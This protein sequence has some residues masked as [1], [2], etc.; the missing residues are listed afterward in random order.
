MSSL[1]VVSSAVK[2]AS[3]GQYI[4]ALAMTRGKLMDARAF[5]EAKGPAWARAAE[6]VKAA[7]TAIGT[8]D[9]AAALLSPVSYDFSELL[10]PLSVIGRLT[11]VQRTPFM[12]RTIAQSSGAS[13]GWLGEAAPVPAGRLT[14]SAGTTLSFAKIVAMT[15]V[16]KEL[17][18][19]SDPSVDVILATDCAKATALV[20]DQAFLDPHNA[21]IFEVRPAS[22]TYSAPKVVSTGSTLAQI[23]ADLGSALNALNPDLDFTSAAWVMHP[24]T[25]IFLSRVRGSGGALAYPLVTARGGSL[26]GL[27]VVTSSACTDDDSPPARFIALI[28]ASEVLLADDNQASLDYSEEASVQMV[29][30]P[31]AGP[32]QSVSLWQNNLV[33]IRS[34]RV[35]NWQPRRP[36]AA[37]TITQVG[38]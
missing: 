9:S 15:V 12:T 31:G 25:A 3:V 8:G 18:K 35:I 14:L 26:M 36:N 16:T 10:R 33:G 30:V 23:D 19:F 38:Y 1:P 13:A 17:A 27:P 11:G 29:D 5:A 34:D 32:Q 37:V 28:V 6:S 4:K 21:G 24:R 2:H 7:V 22:V 20:M